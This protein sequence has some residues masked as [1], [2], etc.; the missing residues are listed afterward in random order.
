MN[1]H[2]FVT[3]QKK[4]FAKPIPVF[5]QELIEEGSLIPHLRKKKLR[6]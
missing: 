5:M 2:P 6:A 4:F 1:V 3:Q